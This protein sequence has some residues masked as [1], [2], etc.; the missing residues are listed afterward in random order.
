MIEITI[1]RENEIEVYI[2]PERKTKMRM[3]TFLAEGYAP[4]LMEIDRDKLPDL[5]WQDK[6]P[7]KPI[8]AEVQKQ[9]D[10]VRY[11]AANAKLAEL[12]KAPKPR[13]LSF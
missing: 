13:R 10:R 5:A 6:N 8:P 3:I 2:T 12:A 1:D 11:D 9:G 4:Q 7:G